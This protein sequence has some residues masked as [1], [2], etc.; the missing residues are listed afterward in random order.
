VTYL[1]AFFHVLLGVLILSAFHF[2]FD[3][4]APLTGRELEEIK[5]YYANAYR[6]N[7]GDQSTFK[8]IEFSEAAVQGGKIN[9]RIAE[10]VRQYNLKDRPILDIGSG[11]GYLQDA[12]KDYTG[13]DISS[14]VARFYHKK[15]VLGSATAMPFGDNSFAGAWS[16]WV[17]EHVPNPEQMLAETRR[18]LR[19][20]GVL[21]L[22][23][24]WNT[25]PWLADG[26]N[27]RPYSDFGLKGKII[28]AS[29]PIRAS[30]F[31]HALTLLPVRF[32]RAVAGLAGATTLHYRR[33]EPNYEHYWTNDSDA[34]NSIDMHEVAMWFESR[35]D[36][37][38][39]CEGSAI[40]SPMVDLPLIIRINKAQ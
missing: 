18:V 9:E 6:P 22:M 38:L 26:Y 12:A 21:F 3:T 34:V 17:L 10:F 35:G 19:D 7:D 14:T 27:V 30:Q 4:D 23:P 24:A 39:S 37:C 40:F 25:P 8:N 16:I 28:K 15:F 31:F 5:R 33:L 29:V 32:A 36:E 11:R 13:L 2:P 20:K 1:R